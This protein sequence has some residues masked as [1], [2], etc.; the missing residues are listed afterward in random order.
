MLH[1]CMADQLTSGLISSWI[2][3]GK[4]LAKKYALS[5]LK[6]QIIAMH[7]TCNNVLQVSVHVKL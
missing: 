5:D 7:R 6:N 1:M 3:T 4:S 2:A